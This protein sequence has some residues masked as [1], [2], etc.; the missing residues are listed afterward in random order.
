MSAST[1]AGITGGWSRRRFVTR[2]EPWCLPDTRR[3]LQLS[4]AAAWLFDGVLQLER[5]ISEDIAQ[6]LAQRGHKIVRPDKPLGGAQAIW[7]DHDKGTLTGGSDPRKDGMA[8]G[9]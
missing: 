9:Y 3:I 2:S 6:N 8:L 1:V 4:L 7:I 5:G